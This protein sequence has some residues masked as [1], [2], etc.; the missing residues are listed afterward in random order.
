MS[1]LY[2]S[3]WYLF[4]LN[5]CLLSAYYVKRAVSG[6][7]NIVVYK[8]EILAFEKLI[9]KGKSYIVKNK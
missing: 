5:K 1:Y 9:L 8:T 3:R 4:I 6:N 2:I 7:G